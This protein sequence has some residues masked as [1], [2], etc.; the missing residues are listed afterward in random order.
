M[1][2]SFLPGFEQRI[3]NEPLLIQLFFNALHSIHEDFALFP[4]IRV[5][6][7]HVQEKL[8][9]IMIDHLQDVQQ[10]FVPFRVD[11]LLRSPE[12]R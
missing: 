8:P 6:V 1:A 7:V 2:L 4:G 5:I 9:G 3:A 10:S 11:Q 12:F